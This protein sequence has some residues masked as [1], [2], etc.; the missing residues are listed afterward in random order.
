MIP[1]CYENPPITFFHY[2]AHGV[3]DRVTDR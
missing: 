2:P 1:K 3:T